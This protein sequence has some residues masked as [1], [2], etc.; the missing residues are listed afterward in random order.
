MRSVIGHVIIALIGLGLP[1]LSGCAEDNG[2]ELAKGI[3]RGTRPWLAV[4][5]QWR[6]G[7]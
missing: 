3:Q 4:R 7:L 2:G 5:R 6:G 1:A